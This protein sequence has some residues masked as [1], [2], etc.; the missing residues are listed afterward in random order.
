[1]WIVF[2]TVDLYIGL[3]V[4]DALMSSLPVEK[5][6]RAN[7]AKKV[8]VALLVLLAIALVAVLVKRWSV[9]A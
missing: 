4:L 5:R 8:V 1:M 6:R 7:V 9:Q 3:V 2:T